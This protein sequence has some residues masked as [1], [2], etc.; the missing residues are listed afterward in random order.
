L[1]ASFC[2]KNVALIARKIM[3][4]PH[5]WGDCSPRSPSPGWYAYACNHSARHW[6]Q[7]C[8]GYLINRVLEMSALCFQSSRNHALK[9][10]TRQATLL[11]KTAKQIVARNGDFGRCCDNVAFSGNVDYRPFNVLSYSR[12][13]RPTAISFALRC[14]SVRTS[15]F[16]YKFYGAQR[17]VFSVSLALIILFGT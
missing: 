4:L 7:C 12:C 15:M 1:S 3:P 9:A 14:R 2:P 10:C 5:S 13:F 8:R 11:P 6:R 16:T 17:P